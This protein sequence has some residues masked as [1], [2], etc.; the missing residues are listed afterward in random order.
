MR[1]RR[2]HHEGV[3]LPGK[4]NVV[5][6][7]AFAGEQPRVFLAGERRADARTR[8]GGIL[9]RERQGRCLSVLN[10]DIIAATMNPIRAIVVALLSVAAPP[11]AAQGYPVESFPVFVTHSLG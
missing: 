5:A 9:G 4:I 3:G 10:R 11:L 8:A 2:A 7:A 6:V 1:V